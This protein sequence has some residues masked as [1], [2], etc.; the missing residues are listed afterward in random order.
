MYA[1]PAVD[2]Q[3][4][5]GADRLARGTDQLLVEAG[6]A[7]ERAP[8]ELQRPVAGVDRGAGEA[9]TPSGVSGMTSLA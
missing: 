8:A 5:L 7:A 3:R 9:M 1:W 2:H 6:V 4:P